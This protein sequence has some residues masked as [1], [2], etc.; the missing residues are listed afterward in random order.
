MAILYITDPA[1]LEAVA[2]SQTISLPASLLR[3]PFQDMRKLERDRRMA[4]AQTTTDRIN[5]NRKG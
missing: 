5:L 1:Q 4:R 3:A 2:S